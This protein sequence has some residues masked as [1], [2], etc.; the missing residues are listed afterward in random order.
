MAVRSGVRKSGGPSR[1]V[2][3]IVEV[4]GERFAMQD[5]DYLQGVRNDEQYLIGRCQYKGRDTIFQWWF[6][7]VGI[8]I[9]TVMP[10]DGEAEVKAKQAWC[11]EH[12]V[13]YFGPAD[14]A[15]TDMIRELAM[16]RRAAA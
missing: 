15:D 10:R 1:R 9:D 7:H 14:C 11:A 13:I 2:H 4:V 6:P 16:E 5:V 3:P 8:A 12:L